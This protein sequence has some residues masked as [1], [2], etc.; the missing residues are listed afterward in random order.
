MD[1]YNPEAQIYGKN[2]SASWS[3]A[4]PGVVISSPNPVNLSYMWLRGFKTRRFLTDDSRFRG[5]ETP[6]PIAKYM[7]LVPNERHPQTNKSY[8]A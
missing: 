4:C 3:L 1:F 5:L 6:V 2:S 8:G 7:C